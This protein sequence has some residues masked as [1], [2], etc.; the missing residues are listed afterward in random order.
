MRYPSRHRVVSLFYP[1]TVRSGMGNEATALVVVPKPLSTYGYLSDSGIEADV[2]SDNSICI[3][4]DF[5]RGDSV[6]EL[7]TGN[8]EV[9]QDAMV[10]RIKNADLVEVSQ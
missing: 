5:E 4:L 6:K 2:S 8:V 3:P 10:E 7:K 1:Y 9:C